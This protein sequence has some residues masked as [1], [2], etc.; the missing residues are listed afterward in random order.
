MRHRGRGGKL[1]AVQR[2]KDCKGRKSEKLCA[3]AG[4]GG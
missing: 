1:C 4:Y 2:R 3:D